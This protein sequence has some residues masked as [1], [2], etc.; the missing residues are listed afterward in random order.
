MIDRN[1]LEIYE[2]TFGTR[3]CGVLV[4]LRVRSGWTF[5]EI[6]KTGNVLYYDVTFRCIRATIVTVGKQ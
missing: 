5:E 6:N 2:I 1:L 4:C 3:T